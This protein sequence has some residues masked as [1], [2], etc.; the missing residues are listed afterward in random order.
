M[1]LTFF[2]TIHLSGEPLK[3][4]KIQASF[5]EGRILDL[6]EKGAEMTPCEVWEAYNRYYPNVPL[7]SIRR[8]MTCLTEKGLLIKGEKMREGIYGK[9]NHTWIR[10]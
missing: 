6:M 3:Q 5:Q 7:T 10:K 1:Q 2:N 4:A 9:L 8:A